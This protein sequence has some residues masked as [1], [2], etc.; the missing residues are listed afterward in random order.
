[1]NLQRPAGREVGELPG[2]RDDRTDGARAELVRV[3]DLRVYFRSRRGFFARRFDRP[4]RAVDGVTLAILRGETLALVGESG[5]GK[6]SLGRGILRLHTPTGGRVLFDGTDLASLSSTD[7][8][9]TRRRMQLI[10]QDPYSSLNPRMSVET[11]IG[12]AMEAHGLTR[13]RETRERVLELLD[14]VGMPASAISRYPHEFSGGQRQRI[15]VARALAVGPEFLVAD[16][17]VSAL[18]VSIQAQVLNLLQDLQEELHLTYLF[19]AHD[20]AVVRQVA[21]RVAVMYL[22]RLMELSPSEALYDDPLHPYTRALLAAVPV[23]D[24]AVARARKPQMLKGE[25][26]SP[27]DPPSGCRFRTRCPLRL[28]LGEP[29]ACAEMEPVLTEARPGRWVACHFADSTREPAT[30]DVSSG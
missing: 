10:F 8:R 30:Y 4:V 16:E 14:R 17:P 9:R 5:S 29:A 28:A 23:P 21:D 12:E 25:I 1:M 2:P 15:G 13:G 26:P 22:G 3:D 24:P 19:L 20:L 7:L 27:T 6:S 18:D 11:L